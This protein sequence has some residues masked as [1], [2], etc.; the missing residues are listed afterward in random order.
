MRI[1]KLPDSE[2]DV[3]QVLWALEPPVPRAVVEEKIRQTAP[4]AQ[5]TILTMLG[6]LADKGFVKA[7]KQGR[8]SVYTPLV[9]REEYLASQSRR[10]F[11]KVCGGSVSAFASALTDSGISKDD[12][13]ELSRLLE[14]GRL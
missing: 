7:E 5:T 2:L 14:E 4:L 6:R 10:F 9:S 8:S 11:E 3:M 1:I 12:L 13:A